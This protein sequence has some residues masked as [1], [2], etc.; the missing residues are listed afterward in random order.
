MQGD[1]AQGAQIPSH[2]MM[3]D[4]SHPTSLILSL[5]LHLPLPLSLASQSHR[6]TLSS[7]LRSR[8]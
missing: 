5:S 1:Q 4:P 3:I 2:V 8:T 6:L 7:I